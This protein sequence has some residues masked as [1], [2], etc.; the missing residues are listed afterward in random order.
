[1]GG[2]VEGECVG[3]AVKQQKYCFSVFHHDKPGVEG[4][5][6]LLSGCEGRHRVATAGDGDGDDEDDDDGDAA[7]GVSR[8]M[9]AAA[10]AY[11][12]ASS[13]RSHRCRWSGREG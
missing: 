5:R 13:E 6:W 11:A 4:R 8:R 12:A 10:A 9:R 2:R 3:E 1:M 7:C